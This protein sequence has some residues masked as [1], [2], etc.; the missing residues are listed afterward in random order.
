MKYRSSIETRFNIL[1][2]LL[3]LLTA[4]G[5]SAFL[6]IEEQNKAYQGLIRYGD[7]IAQMLA[8]NSEHGIHTEN[9]EVLHK[10]IKSLSL[11]KDIAYTVIINK[12]DKILVNKTFY[13][14]VRTPL[15]A[16]K[17]VLKKGVPLITEFSMSGNDAAF[18]DISLPVYTAS[19]TH[20]D[21]QSID[22]SM[23]DKDSELIGYIQLGLNQQAIKKDTADFFYNTLLII[24]V[25][26][27]IGSIL[28]LLMTRKITSPIAS[29]VNATKRIAQGDFSE[30]IDIQS[31]DEIGNLAQSFNSMNKRLQDY[32]QEV[33][34]QRETLEEKVIKRTE[35]LQK[36]TDKAEAANISKSQFLANMSHEIRTPMNAVLGMTEFLLDSNLSEEQHGFAHT[37]YKSAESL[38]S[39]IND[40]LDFSKI[41]AGKLELE[42]I[43]FEL[44]GLVE[45]AVEMVA[46]HGHRKGLELACLVQNDVP[47]VLRADPNR[48]R[49]VLMNLL[50]NAIKFTDKGEVVVRVS[51]ESS[52]DDATILRFEVQDTG[53]GLDPHAQSIIFN[54]FSQADGSTT[55]KYGGTG[56]GLSIAKQL[57]ELMGGEIGVES[58]VGQ[59]STFW[60]TARFDPPKICIEPQAKHSM[61]GFKALIIDDNATNR[62]I[63]EL[64]LK[65]WSIESESAANAYEALERLRAAKHSNQPFDFALLDMQMPEID[66][67]ALAKAIQSEPEIADIRLIMLSSIYQVDIAKTCQEVG[68]DHFLAKPVKQSYL[69]N[70]IAGLMGVSVP[71]LSLGNQGRKDTNEKQCRFTTRVLVAEDYPANQLVIRQ[72]LTT[73]GCQ[74][75]IVDNGV[76]ALD[77]LSENDYDV[78]FMDCQMPRMDGYEATQHI[79]RKEAAANTP[80]H[81]PIIALTANALD[82]DREKCLAAGMDDYLSKPF[83]RNQIH[84]ILKAWSPSELVHD[85][86][87]VTPA[88]NNVTTVNN[89]A[90]EV[91]ENEINSDKKLAALTKATLNPETINNIRAMDQSGDLG[92]L[93]ELSDIF[94]ECAEKTLM[95]LNDAVN[96]RDADSIRKL[97]HDFKSS[98]ANVGATQL[99]S[100]T[101]E[102]ENNARANDLTE[103]DSLLEKVSEEYSSVAQAL[104]ELCKDEQCE[105]ES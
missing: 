73:L 15:L 40:I 64:Q 2:T 92:F 87:Q 24:S 36:A 98:S 94:I 105:S 9:R 88:N 17:T 56:L 37:V 7:S 77:A 19:Q 47:N 43:D 26:V 63:F 57:V 30:H 103:I 72:M 41:E 67:I 34:Q 104:T 85:V 86:E 69:Y 74:L 60:F 46:E 52:I 102:M 3:I 61:Q 8:Y 83:N 42:K 68:I 27:L 33:E 79:R 78:I 1:T 6:I 91:V 96:T 48:L 97:A 76:K 59:G 4:V 100:L 14:G 101:R 55:R 28:T 82:G 81:I 13:P 53:I 35:D 51:S 16:E 29:L 49:Q 38:L 80:L 11:N 58:K 32:Q 31:N 71:S 39:I 65:S 20:P 22:S 89:V 62:E 44:C 95:S 84:Q 12:E 18:I 10:I 90:T 75:D 23:S 54:S 45:D 5:T 21:D 93:S 66:G 70:T 99:A 25:M 50:S